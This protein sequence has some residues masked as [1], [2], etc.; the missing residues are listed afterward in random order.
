[1]YS[2]S[3]KAAMREAAARDQAMAQAI[4]R[5][6]ATAVLMFRQEPEIRR[7]AQEGPKPDGGDEALVRQVADFTVQTLEW[8]AMNLES[9]R[10]ARG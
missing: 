4:E 8:L 6:T 3:Q 2:E 9:K 1:M 7:V 10:A 5:V